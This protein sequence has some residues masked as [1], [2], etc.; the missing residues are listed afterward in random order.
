MM[1]SEKKPIPVW[2]ILVIGSVALLVGIVAFPWQRLRDSGCFGLGG[3]MPGGD[4]NV[5]ALWQKRVGGTVLLHVMFIPHGNTR[6]MGSSGAYGGVPRSRGIDSM[7]EGLFIDGRR[8]GP[9]ADVRVF[10]LRKDTTAEGIP[11]TPEELRL[12]APNVINNLSMTDV[13]KDKIGPI[14]ERETSAKK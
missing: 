6:S 7:P 14:V 9:S 10:V 12:F 13:W 11:L 2:L 4:C 5:E 8:L 1:H 3:A